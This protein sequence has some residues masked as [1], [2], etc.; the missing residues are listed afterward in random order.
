VAGSQLNYSVMWNY[1]DFYFADG[2]FDGNQIAGAPEN[3]LSGRV[4]L[5]L[6]DFTLGAG[7]YGQPDNNPV[8]HANTLQQDSFWLLGLDL[9]YRPTPWLRTYVAIN[10]V[11]DETYNAAYVV[12][13]RSEAILPTFL[14]GNGRNFV[15]GI[16][17]SW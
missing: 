16:I 13:D 14:P 5:P 11:T 8:D 2:V 4:S 17:L 3:V 1:S 12:R 6:A 9:N 10:N 7:V 15:A